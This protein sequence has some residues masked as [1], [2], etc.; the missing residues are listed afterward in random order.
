MSAA[1]VTSSVTAPLP[2]KIASLVHEARWLLIGLVGI[3]LAL[4]LWGYDRADPGWSHAAALERV[5]NPGGRFGA[6]LADLLLYLLGL[7]SWWLA[8]LPFFLL[9]WGYH[10]LSHI[11]GGDR[12]SLLI[13]LGGFV[14]LLLA[15]AGVEGM[16]FWSLKAALPLAPGGML[17]YEV[18]RLTTQFLGYTGGTLILLVVAMIGSVC[19][20]ACPGSL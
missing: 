7:S 20:P 16:R 4:V 13:A 9:A 14:V 17:G 6:W 3:Y 10:R 11:F 2:E 5:S 12:R 8:V 1:S 19:L 15:C 18:G